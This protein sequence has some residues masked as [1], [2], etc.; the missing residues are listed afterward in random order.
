MLELKNTYGAN[1]IQVLIVIAGE[2]NGDSKF[3]C[4]NNFTI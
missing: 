2:I 3:K 1:I 4:K